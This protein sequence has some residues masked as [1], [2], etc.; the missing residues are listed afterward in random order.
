[1]KYLL[2]LCGKNVSLRCVQRALLHD[3]K[4]AFYLIPLPL[5]LSKPIPTD[6][7]LPTPR[8]DLSGKRRQLIDQVGVVSVL[9]IVISTAVRDDARV[10][11]V[12]FSYAPRVEASL[13][14]EVFQYPVRPNLN[15]ARPQP[16]AFQVGLG[17]RPLV[18]VVQYPTHGGCSTT[19]QGGYSDRL[20]LV[21]R[22]RPPGNVNAG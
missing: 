16:E 9:L 4:I 13:N 17:N 18:A 2:D 5:E 6:G 12:D 10:D 8:A 3:L 21:K 22:V 1:M 19:I 11:H 15:V 7:T 14:E 20:Q